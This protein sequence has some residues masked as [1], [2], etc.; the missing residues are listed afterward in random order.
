MEK[1]QDLRIT[2]TH[3]ALCNAFVVLLGEK[4]FE[5]ITVNE[6]CERAMVRRATFYKH[7]SDKYYFF[8]FFIREKQAEFENETEPVD[9]ES[10]SFKYVLALTVRLIDY[11]EDN[12]KII[13]RVLESNMMPAMLDIFSEQMIFNVK[14][15]LKED[16]A[17]GIEPPASPEFCAVAYSGAILQ[18][19]RWWYTQK[20]GMSKDVL[21]SEL[22]NV[23]SVLLG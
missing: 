15:K 16:K 10:S 8:G 19:L 22:N 21:I 17:K 20:T 12:K 9:R 6:L 11:L 2:K 4:R 5:D 7:F 3:M 18:V 14:E 13:E 23:F 1:Q